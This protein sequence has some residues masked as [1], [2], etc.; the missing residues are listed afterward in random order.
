MD[1]DT[2]FSWLSQA[3]ILKPQRKSPPNQNLDTCTT[4]IIKI[5]IP[6]HAITYLLIYLHHN[7]HIAM[8]KL[9]CVDFE[10]LAAKYA[11]ISSILFL[12]SYLAF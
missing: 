4:P 8:S 9:S 5:F 7:L 2:P 6:A 12:T 11:L 3:F 1:G 10:C